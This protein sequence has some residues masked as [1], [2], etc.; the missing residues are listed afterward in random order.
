M[1]WLCNNCGE[2]VGKTNTEKSH[3]HVQALETGWLCGECKEHTNW[4]QH[5]DHFDEN[6]DYTG[7]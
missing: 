6:G 5:L 1:T 4:K 7:S 2:T 3:I